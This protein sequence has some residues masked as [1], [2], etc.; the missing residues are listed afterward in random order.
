MKSCVCPSMLVWALHL[1]TVWALFGHCMGTVR[2]LQNKGNIFFSGM[3]AGSFC[4]SLFFGLASFSLFSILSSLRYFLF[5]PCSSLGASA[6]P[7]HLPRPCPIPSSPFSFL[8]SLICLLSLSVCF[9][10][11]PTTFLTS[12]LFAFFSPE[13]GH[14]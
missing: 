14:D 6:S 11:C 8:L 1:G 2:A 7:P 12:P 4:S 5:A 3:A 9:C 13:R 10:I